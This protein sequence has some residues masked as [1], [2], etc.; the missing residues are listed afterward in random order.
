[1]NYN[2]RS[3]SR[4]SNNRRDNNRCFKK[5]FL[6]FKKKIL[7]FVVVFFNKTFLI[8]IV[9]EMVT[10]VLILL[11][12]NYRFSSLKPDHP[13]I[14]NA[15]VPL[16]ETFSEDEALFQPWS[17]HDEGF[18][19]QNDLSSEIP[20]YL[21]RDN[22]LYNTDQRDE[23]FQPWSDHD[24]GFVEQNDLSSERPSVFDLPRDNPLYNTDQREVLLERPWWYT[25]ER[26]DE[27]LDGWI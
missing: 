20:S 4:G 8:F 11:V 23:L 24:E 16:H 19:E 2:T 1:M 26:N 17:D 18:V 25:E 9:K 6:F 12:I 21:S 13:L 22:P 7:I 14:I 5:I 10:I 27:E 3:N 15:S